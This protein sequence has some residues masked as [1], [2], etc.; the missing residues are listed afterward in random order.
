[1]REWTTRRVAAHRV[2][3]FHVGPSQLAIS[4][5]FEAQ[6]SGRVLRVSEMDQQASV[7]AL[8]DAVAGA[9]GAP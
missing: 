4:Q 9:R 5:I 7:R 6:A 3:F 8:Q 2:G 1:M